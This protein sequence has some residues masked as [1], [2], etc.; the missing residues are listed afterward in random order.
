M[1]KTD[2]MN[3][4]KFGKDKNNIDNNTNLDINYT[5]LLKSILEDD[6]KTAEPSDIVYVDK[7]KRKFIV[8]FSIKDP[9]V[10]NCQIILQDEKHLLDPVALIKYQI[11]PNGIYIGHFKTRYDYQGTGLGK[12]LY[13]LAQAHA[14]LL[15][16]PSS[17]GMICPVGKIKGV[18]SDR[19]NCT[20]KEYT[21]LT[22][23][24]HALGNTITKVN[25]GDIDILT[26]TD[27][28][29]TGE[30]IV[31]LNDEQLKFIKKV[32]RYEKY[33]HNEYLHRFDYLLDIN[34]EKK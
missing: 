20:E 16:T 31:K 32:A 30:K 7:A 33:K 23:M 14:D 24:Y 19:E 1:K 25:A 6:D 11:T 9:Q 29:K 5:F 8:S 34:S 21:F 2:N 4:S 27:K 12:Y 22:L 10:R 3:K 26:F 13:Q 17:E 18:S 15:K 28:W